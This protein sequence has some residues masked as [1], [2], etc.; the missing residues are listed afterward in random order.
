MHPPPGQTPLRKRPAREPELQMATKTLPA[1]LTEILTL[2]VFGAPS[3]MSA[4][5]VA[6]LMRVQLTP[7]STDWYTPLLAPASRTVV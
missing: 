3:P 1:V 5:M 4:F 6:S 7:V 2:T